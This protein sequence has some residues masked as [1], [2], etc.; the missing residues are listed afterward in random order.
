MRLL[1]KW[2]DEYNEMHPHKGFKTQSPT[3]TE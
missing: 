1:P 2:L 3:E